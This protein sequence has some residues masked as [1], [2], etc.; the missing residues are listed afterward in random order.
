MALL[1]DIEISSNFS[2]SEEQWNALQRYSFFDWLN[3]NDSFFISNQT[4]SINYNT[5][6]INEATHVAWNDD[7]FQGLCNYK[8]KH[9]NCFVPF[10]YKS[11]PMLG[12]WVYSIQSLYH[13]VSEKTESRSEVIEQFFTPS[14]IQKLNSINF[15]QEVEK[16]NSE[17]NDYFVETSIQSYYNTFDYHIHQLKTFKKQHG[18]CNVPLTTELGVWLIQQKKYLGFFLKNKQISPEEESILTNYQAQK[19]LDLEVTP[20]N[21]FD[22][23][24][25]APL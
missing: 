8:K 15:F 11:N 22:E 13:H 21:Y 18:H 24:D 14:Q 1:N 10:I 20:D 19:L 6:I 7:L 25:Y 4:Y 9:G 23:A 2:L 12:Y 16:S 17:T 3:D 5:S